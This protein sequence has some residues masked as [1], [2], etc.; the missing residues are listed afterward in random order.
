MRTLASGCRLMVRMKT[1]RSNPTSQR[2]SY[3]G[4]WWRERGWLGTGAS[5]EDDRARSIHLL[6]RA[7][8]AKVAAFV[9][10]QDLN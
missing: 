3:R 9:W 1:V 4:Y 5:P 8:T 6:H 10:A 7:A 2:F